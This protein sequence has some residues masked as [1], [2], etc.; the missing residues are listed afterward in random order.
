[1]ISP[2]SRRRILR[3]ATF[4]GTAIVLIAATGLTAAWL[5]L[6]ASLPQVDGARSEAGMAQPATIAR[7]AQG[8][9]TIRAANRT[10]AAY[11]T[12]FA[13]AQ[14]RFF[15]MDLVRRSAAG[16]LAALVGEAAVPLDRRVRVHR[17]RAR[18][19]RAYAALPPTHRT[20]LERYAAGVNAGLEALGA[21]PFE[22]VLLGGPPQP[23]QPA[24]TLLAIYAMY[25]DLQG[26]ELMRV[27]SRDALRELLPGP[28]LAALL[29]ARSRWDAPLD[30]PPSSAGSAPPDPALVEA[31]PDWIDRPRPP[32]TNG[33]IPAELM[34][35]AGTAS[36][37]LGS[38]GWAIDARHG[39]DGRALV[40]NDMHLG[41]RL[42][43][44]W[45]RLTL[46][47]PSAS[48]PRRI[49]G[50]SLP[51]APIVV[52]GSN[53]DVAW[54]FTNS[55]GHFI[56][57]V[58]L[59]SDAADPS[60][61]R[62]PAGA[63]E[64]A[65][66][67][68]ERID[69]KGAP[70]VMLPV[71]ETPWG[72]LRQN[73]EKAYAIRW[74]AYLPDAADVR[75]A[76]MEDARDIGQAMHV[77]QTAGIPTQNLV[78]ADRAGNIGWTLA[79]PLPTSTLDPLGFPVTAA[80]ADAPLGRLAPSDY[81]SVTEP[82]YGR[83][84]TANSTQLADEDTQRRIGDGGADVGARGTQ[85]RNA[86]FAGER[87]NERDLL[88]IQ[89]DDRAAW[90]AFLRE[91]AL[92]ELDEAAVA[93]H[94]QRA[95]FRRILQSW[96]GRADAGSTGYALLRAY[97][98]ALYDAWFG[99][100]DEKLAAI[101]GGL[102]MRRASSRVLATMESLVRAR[103]W[104]PAYAADWRAFMLERI[105]TAIAS[106]A[107]GDRPLDDIRWGDRNRLA[108]E[109]P[110]ARVLPAAVRPWLSAPVRPMPGDIHMPRI[111]GTSFG[112][113]ERF[114]VSPGHEEHGLMEM[115]GGAS[116]HPLSPFFL[117]GHSAWTDGEATPFLPGPDVH[118]L[119][120][121]PAGSGH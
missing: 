96:N 67:T 10:D 65:A 23:W 83:L 70:P 103:A 98:D 54:G 74:I 118:R 85:I 44:I 77:A 80:H 61:Y 32:R 108:M 107:A 52:A 45:Y 101:D 36:S 56:D 27:R 50:V 88:A 92:A 46:E 18:A 109:H 94:P 68:V 55:Y 49:S 19:E 100:L 111:Q 62:G 89:L 11:A 42:P 29:P 66:E 114:V 26:G 2:H 31:H 3:R 8:S 21:R 82:A 120:L 12:G 102:S 53:G 9:V 37:A 69:V 24:D 105:D 97:H 79:G 90:V 47:F 64:R 112:A 104:K 16:E 84:W 40:A 73:G 43:N 51:G 87:F 119:T 4:A 71:R 121:V 81:P 30:R 38:N 95:A 34:V 22:Y 72:P 116:G 63:W 86:L 91:Q 60:R 75:L 78:V 1:M 115:P 13:H 15:Q 58:K 39:A 59:E 7:D 20:L 113:S 28:L 57:L 17:F 35:D 99:A 14:D 5:T 25:L 106:V 117:A 76:G 6:R 41:L 93:G 33:A 110:L 48:G